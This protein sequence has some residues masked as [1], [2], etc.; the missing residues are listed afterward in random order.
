VNCRDAHRRARR[1]RPRNRAKPALV[2]AHGDHEPRAEPVARRGRSRVAEPVM[3][4]VGD[5]RTSPPSRVRPA[6]RPRPPGLRAAVEGRASSAIASSSSSSAS[7]RRTAAAQGRANGG[8]GRGA[9]TGDQR[10]I[11]SVKRA[12]RALRLPPAPSDDDRDPLGRLRP[13][14]GL[15]SGP[16]CGA[17]RCA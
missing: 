12:G 14:S 2:A 4:D 3:F 5:T 10:S 16:E 9:R 17:G 11:T 13:R 6:R 1:H 8:S 7:R 15:R